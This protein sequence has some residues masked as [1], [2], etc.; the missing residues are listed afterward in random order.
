MTQSFGLGL[1]FHPETEC[2]SHSA[3]FSV[4]TRRQRIAGINWN[5]L[6]LDLMPRVPPGFICRSAAFL[7]FPKQVCGHFMT[8]RGCIEF[9]YNC[10]SIPSIRSLVYVRILRWWFLTFTG[11]FAEQCIFV[12]GL[13]LSR[14]I[15]RQNELFKMAFAAT[16]DHVNVLV[17]QRVQN[18]F[19]WCGFGSRVKPASLFG[20]LA[21][22]THSG[23]QTDN[24][25]R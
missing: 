20:L 13:R 21:S 23:Q 4:S 9:R 17:K 15:C 6:F 12:T 8:I 22:Q 5:G 16:F 25:L 14:Q 1:R 3:A 2:I 18:P 10:K 19:V 11:C 24:N 7:R